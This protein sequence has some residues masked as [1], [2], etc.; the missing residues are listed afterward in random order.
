MRFRVDARL[1]RETLNE[2]DYTRSVLQNIRNIISTRQGSVPN[3]REFGL[4]MD[5]L[6]QPMPV[7]VPTLIVEVREALM[8]WEPRAKLIDVSFTADEDGRL[9]PVVEVEITNEES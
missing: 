9:F 1:D 4:P 2:N 5:F 8:L 3:F 7:A 6:D